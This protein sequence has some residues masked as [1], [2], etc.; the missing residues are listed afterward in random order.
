MYYRVSKKLACPLRSSASQGLYW[1]AK[2]NENYNIWYGAG[3]PLLLVAY[4]G[5]GPVAPKLGFARS[6]I[7]GQTVGWDFQDVSLFLSLVGVP[8]SWSSAS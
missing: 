3:M 5:P 4:N 6:R 7:S 8:I 2:E 1:P